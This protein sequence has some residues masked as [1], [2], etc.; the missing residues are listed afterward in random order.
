M[1]GGSYSATTL[2]I[3]LWKDMNR[4]TFVGNTVG[5]ANWGSFAGQ[6]KDLKLKNSKFKVHI[7]LMKLVHGH[8][9]KT[10]KTFF[11]EPDYYVDQSFEDFFR[12]KDSPMDFVLDLIKN[13]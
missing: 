3:G 11:V 4:A 8:P 7:P 6:W 5:G 10:N 12:R 9:N 2:T 1:D 13:K